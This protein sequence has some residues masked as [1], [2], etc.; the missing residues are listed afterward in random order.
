[1]G[2]DTPL[3]DETTDEPKPGGLDHENFMKIL[4]Q[5]DCLCMHGAACFNQVFWEG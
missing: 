1:M 4:E 5:A 2:R 3:H